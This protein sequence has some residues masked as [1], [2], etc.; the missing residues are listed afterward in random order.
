MEETKGTFRK[1]K[2]NFYSRLVQLLGDKKKK[3][4]CMITGMPLIK[5]SR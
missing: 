5:D 3:I 2:L 1:D 4:T